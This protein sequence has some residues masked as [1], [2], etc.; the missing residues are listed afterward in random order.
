MGPREWVSGTQGSAT[1]PHPKASAPPE[2]R[3]PR[4]GRP[5]LRIL[6]ALAA[7][8]MSASSA[9][10]DLR[11][12]Y[13]G[14]PETWPAP[15]ID[16]GVDFLEFAAVPPPPPLDGAAMR[17]ADLG[18][19]LFG[20]PRLAADG[21]LACAG[22]HEPAQGWTVRTP[23]GRGHAGRPGRR[24]PPDLRAVAILGAWGWAGGRLALA[25]QVLA[26]L[27][28][29]DEMANRGL[30]P[31]LDRLAA[32][33][34]LAAAFDEAFPGAG[35]T[36]ETLAA[37]LIAHL[38]R[39]DTPT[40]FDRFASGERTALSDRE[41]AGLHLFRTRAGCA[42]CHHG[43]LLRDGRFHN[44]RLSAFGEPGQDLGR[45]AVTGDPDDAGRFRTPSLRH[46]RETAPYGHAGLF[47]TLAGVVNL[48]D[49]GGGEV[50]ARNA[51][52][53]ARPLH[54]PAARLSP[55]IRPLGL[56]AEE[57]AALVAFLE[58]L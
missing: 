24:N 49:R 25:A 35:L 47:P 54:A 40:R 8:L 10:L 53:A 23:T 5:I 43:P 32:D 22:C 34:G 7:I 33:P 16:P 46:I 45:F 2:P 27:T 50:W 13:A 39:I 15:W 55:H 21:Q 48:Y 56:T 28:D 4:A 42:A 9:G 3:S 29:P 58:T 51:A 26:P 6:A 52:E 11:R 37:A 17:R 30:D 57:K 41:V 38:G 19:R 1:D 14:P 20:D 36:A 18:A 44:L 12:A 31:L